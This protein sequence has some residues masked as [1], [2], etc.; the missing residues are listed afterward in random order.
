M[1][2]VVLIQLQLFGRWVGVDHLRSR[3]VQL[4]IHFFINCT[5]LLG[6]VKHKL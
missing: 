2:Q 6:V 5:L 1:E 4:A 3:D